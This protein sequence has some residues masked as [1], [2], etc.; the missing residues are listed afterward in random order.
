VGVLHGFRGPIR[1]F[2]GSKPPD[3]ASSLTTKMM[4]RRCSSSVTYMQISIV[5]SNGSTGDPECCV[6][7]VSPIPHQ[8]TRRG[9]QKIQRKR[10]KLVVFPFLVV[11]TTASRY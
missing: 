5:P 10:I 8:S 9:Q 2:L 11:A 4:P 1:L 7:F 3:M 6:N